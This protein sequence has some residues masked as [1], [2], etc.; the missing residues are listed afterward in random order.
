MRGRRSPARMMEAV[1]RGFDER[2]ARSAEPI[3]VIWKR[4]LV[5]PLAIAASVLLSACAHGGGVSRSKIGEHCSAPGVREV[6]EEFGESMQ[7]VSL[8][9]PRGVL[10]QSLRHVYAPFVTPELLNRWLTDPREAPGRSVSS[11][12]PARIEISSIKPIGA[13]SCAITGRVIYLTSNE[14]EHGG[15]FARRSVTLRVR[16]IGQWRISAYT[17]HGGISLTG[18]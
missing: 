17:S 2:I 5:L 12:W 4:N 18:E 10:T 14:V 3:P 13:G 11:P 16:K 15:V 1:D 7:R 6:V 8:L 9:A